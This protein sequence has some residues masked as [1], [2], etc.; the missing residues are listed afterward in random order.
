MITSDKRIPDENDFLLELLEL[1]RP[2]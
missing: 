1:V 2:D